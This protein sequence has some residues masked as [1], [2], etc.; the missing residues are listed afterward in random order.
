M[1]KGVS[2]LVCLLPYSLLL[3][4]GA[5]LGR[6]YYH[7]AVRQRERALEQIQQS[8]GIPP[9]EARVIITRMFIKLGQ[10]FLEVLYM[11]ALN[12][13]RM[14]EYITVENRHYIEEALAEGKGVPILTG[15][16]GNWEWLAAWLAFNG[17]PITA[18]AK[19]QPND[20]HTK[21]INEFRDKVGVKVFCRGTSEMLAAARALKAKKLLG[22]LADQDAGVYGIF[23]KFLGKMASTP[24][25]IA[26]FTRKFDSP[27]LPIFMT[28]RPEGGHRMVV[29]P[30]LRFAKSDDQAADYQLITTETTQ[31]LE[32]FIMKYP[33]EWI[34]F[35]KRWN[36][37]WVGEQS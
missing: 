37:E 32:A 9:Q 2:S 17:F 34:W 8:L 31:A 19:S 28:R 5:C 1:F 13:E 22:F 33:D 7:V 24:T 3:K 26:Y 11:P 21:L 20:Q 14:A 12:A 25:G 4:L 30:I 36:T 29:G 35:Q 27:V 6:I 16:V 15:H 10:T 23:I 18:I